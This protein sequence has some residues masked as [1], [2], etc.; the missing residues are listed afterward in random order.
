MSADQLS[1]LHTEILT[2]LEEVKNESGP[3]A[4]KTRETLNQLRSLV[5][6]T[7]AMRLKDTKQAVEK[8]RTP[9]ESS[10]ALRNA[11]AMPYVT[12]AP[13]PAPSRPILSQNE[14][15]NGLKPTASNAEFERAVNPTGKQTGILEG[16]WNRLRYMNYWFSGL[17]ETS[18]VSGGFFA[19]IFRFF[20]IDR[21]SVVY[22]AKIDKAI[23]QKYQPTPVAPDV[24][25][26]PRSTPTKPTPAPSTP[27]KIEP[28]PPPRRPP[29]ALKDI[30]TEDFSSENF[31]K[32]LRGEAIKV[33]GH[34]VSLGNGGTLMKIDGTGYTCT[35][36]DVDPLNFALKLLLGAVPRTGEFMKS[37]LA[38]FDLAFNADSI[39]A[40]RRTDG[41]QRTINI[42]DMK[43]FIKDTINLHRGGGGSAT[44]SIKF[45]EKTKAGTPE[46]KTLTVTL[47]K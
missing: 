22:K 15:G 6:E 47:A 36:L 18:A 33:A 46:N 35:S 23:E 41:L 26:R 31:K 17:V 16:L 30:P 3:D 27:S 43:S 37:K 19:S 5:M 13:G 24:P 29:I 25:V 1:A 14:R 39:I 4:E 7:V 45:I 34:D 32:F 42:A 11:A 9:P 28:A 12:E 8:L 38:E 44:M 10:P 21:R 20:G 2:K 40:T